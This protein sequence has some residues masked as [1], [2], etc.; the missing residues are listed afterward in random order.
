M[1]QALLAL[2]VISIS[3]LTTSASKDKCDC[4]PKIEM[5][6]EHVKCM[7]SAAEFYNCLMG[8]DLDPENVHSYAF[9][10]YTGEETLMNRVMGDE[11][12]FTIKKTLSNFIL[13]AMSLEFPWLKTVW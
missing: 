13:M 9:Y 2:M 7:N 6:P 12:N 4:I 10:I 5:T 8:T 3:L 1:K 11:W